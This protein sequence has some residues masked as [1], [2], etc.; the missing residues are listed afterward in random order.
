MLFCKRNKKKK[1]EDIRIQ[2]RFLET[3]PHPEK[4][5]L[6]T[7]DFLETGQASPI[8]LDKDNNLIDGYCT[9]L[10]LKTLLYDKV[11][12]VIVR[13]DEEADNLKKSTSNLKKFEKRG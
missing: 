12:C 2:P 13:D 5:I 1:I 7:A 6:K 10:I 3:P 4:L 9:Y 8:Y 11:K